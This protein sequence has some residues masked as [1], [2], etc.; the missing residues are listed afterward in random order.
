[1]L[2]NICKAQRN[3]PSQVPDSA[4]NQLMF[5]ACFI[6]LVGLTKWHQYCFLASSF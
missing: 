4:F 1:M 5:V 2:Y 6:T 3:I